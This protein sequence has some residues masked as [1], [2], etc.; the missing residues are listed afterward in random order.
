MTH[1]DSTAPSPDPFAGTKYRALERIGQGGM[2]EVFL[3]EHVE[4]GREVVVKLLHEQHAADAEMVDRMRVETQTLAR[5]SHPN[6]VAIDDIGRTRDGRPFFVME[7]LRGRTLFQQVRDRGELPLPEA[8]E[9]VRQV[10]GALRAAHQIGVIHRDVKLPNIF[11]HEPPYGEPTV[12]LLDFGLAKV[13]DRA[14]AGAPP[15]LG[16]PTEAGAVLGTPGYMSPE[17]ASGKKLDAR[18]DLYAVGLVLYRLIAGRGPFRAK[19]LELVRAV[20]R[21]RPPP[22][23]QFA[24]EPLPPELEGAVMKALSRN[25][26]HRFQSA[27]EFAS[28]LGLILDAWSLPVGWVP[29]VAFDGS[30]FAGPVPDYIR[31][32]FPFAEAEES[33]APPRGAAPAAVMAAASPPVAQAPGASRPIPQAPGASPPIPQAPGGKPAAGP[34]APEPVADPPRAAPAKVPAAPSRSAGPPAAQRD[35]AAARP[36]GSLRTLAALGIAVIVVAVLAATVVAWAVSRS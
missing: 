11:L 9:V 3:A 10:L 18:S 20:L 17:Q 32:R 16:N 34:P 29:T 35:P 31:E 15:P 8:L 23:S 25:P 22:P 33:S 14:A 7:R 6:I 30:S 19:G 12:K 5:L 21:E 24:K 2:G 26:D 13:I 4:L 28:A 27:E 1:D 36:P